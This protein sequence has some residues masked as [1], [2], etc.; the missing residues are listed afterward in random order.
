MKRPVILSLLLSLGGCAV[1]PNYVAPGAPPQA[2]APFLSSPA[3]ATA[4]DDPP[5]GWWRLY[6]DPVLDGLVQQALTEN[7]D[8]KV[9]A[10]NLAQAEALVSAARVGL[11]P[12]TE[13]SAG[14]TY[15]RSS[16]ANY[17]AE[18]AGKSHA[19]SIWSFST[20]FTAAYQVDLFGQVRRT[21]EAARADR[22]ATR[23]AEDA[24]RVTVAAETTSAYVQAC[25]YAAQTAVAQRSLDEAQQT[26]DIVR[27][28]RD[29]GAVSDF[30]FSRAAASY[31]QAVAVVPGLQSQRRVALLELAALIGKTPAE[32]PADAAACVTPPKLAALLPTG[33]GAALLRRRPDL[34]QAERTLAAD[35]ARIGVATAALY[36][37]ISLGG[38]I[39]DA[40]G[41]ARALGAP[42]DLSYGLGPLI[43]WSFPNIGLARAQIAQTR[44]EAAGALAAFDGDVLQ[45]LK[46]TEQALTTYGGELDR[47]RALTAAAQQSNEALRLAQVQYGAG[48]ISFLDLLTA[49]TTA[50]AADQAEA[51]SDQ[52]VALDQVAVFQALGGGW[53]QAP[54][55]HSPSR[56][57]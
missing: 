16:A 56:G 37:S 20:G 49:Q 46:E 7:A 55:P 44:A 34:R 52:Q 31:N 18:L 6:Q 8:L 13:L 14:E 53:E 36:P 10:A 35:T 33:D 40:G 57:G 24:V 12:S 9:A 19:P 17:D 45:A 27:K 29:L 32:I 50:A 26:F 1:G 22:E 39:A 25:G 4:P 15:G 48:A 28:Q 41:S 23:A 30:D 11:L 42:G 38:S 43:S 47:N 3:E 54:A 51:A 5:P 2:T 21:I